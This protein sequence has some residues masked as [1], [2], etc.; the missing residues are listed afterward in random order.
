[1]TSSLGDLRLAFRGLRRN[2]LF[3]TV[4]ILSLAL[5]IG[6]NTAI[7]TLLDQIVLR[8]LPVKE[9]G[10]LVMLYQDA[11]NMGSNMGQRMHSY[12]LYQDLQQRAEPFS[13]VL[14]RRATEVSFSVGDATE[15]VDAEVV[16][17][18]YFSMLG[19]G[20]A[21]GRVLDASDDVQGGPQMVAVVSDA[22]WRSRMGSRG[23]VI[24]SQVH[25]NGTLFTVIGVAPPTFHGAY[26][27]LATDLWVP[28]MTYETVRP[29]GLPITRR[30]W[31]WLSATAR[32]GSM[33]SAAR[34]AQTSSIGS[35]S[36]DDSSTSAASR[37]R[38]GASVAWRAALTT[39][40]P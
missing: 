31:G 25:L 18:N 14:A 4:A 15:R 9:P 22:W 13:E 37:R 1:M 26:D 11:S 2:P 6:A 20:A 21:R 17:G 23:D 39:R 19:V 40:T 3:A 7:F 16:S 8:Q 35:C 27:A 32:R 33:P 10:A 12:P 34:S 28:L 30:G 38:A 29:R 24:G 36:R 5:G